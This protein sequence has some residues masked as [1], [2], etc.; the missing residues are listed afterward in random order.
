MA[1]SN[2]LIAQLVKV[3]KPTEKGA[4]EASVYGTAVVQNETQYVRI[5]GSDTLTPV[6]ST[7]GMKTNDRVIVRIKD[8]TA[9]VTGNLTSRSASSDDLGAVSDQITDVE[10]LI[11]DRVDSA[12]G[13][14]DTLVSDNVVIKDSL[15]TAEATIA[16]LVA[17]SASIREKLTTNDAVI[18]NLEATKLSA[19][20]ADL[21][22]ASLEDLDAVEAV[23]YNFDATYATITSLDAV[24]AEIEDIEAS[25][26]TAEDA[27]ILYADIEF[28]NIGDAALENLFT[29]SGII[30]NLVVSEGHVTGRL[31]GVTIIGDI[32]EGGTVVADKLVIRGEDGL[33]YKLNTDGETTEAEQ[34]EYN[35]L[36]GRVITAK[37]VTAEKISVNDLVAFGATIGGFNIT[38]GSLFSGVK[39][40]VEN[41]TPGV[42]LG[43]DGQAAFGNAD[44]YLKFYA[45]YSYYQVAFDAVTGTYMRTDTQLSM[46]VGTIVEGALTEDGHRVYLTSINDVE[47]YFCRVATDYKLYISADSILFGT[48]SKYSMNDV[49]QLTDHVKIGSYVDSDT[50]EQ[51]PCVELSE[52]DSD[53]KMRLTNKKASFMD[54]VND[55]TN[56]DSDGVETENLRVKHDIR[57]YDFVWRR[58]ANGN[59]G[60]MW[61]EVTD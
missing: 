24:S 31:T 39:E 53:F 26:L 44:N 51:L 35:S 57:H 20:V 13:R 2:D 47:T 42:F 27:K 37:S 45:V 1:L 50:G 59:L 49:K 34:T 38:D 41:S 48:D 28:A 7:V 29:K 16:V 30:D 12:H 61:M 55:S 19:D 4:T 40:S 11:A 52:S 60:L 56:I 9:T 54:G 43:S 6:E 33:Y 17:D 46:P 8:H 22:Y 10:I 15:N 23:V 5:D 14:I 32:I 25:M 21:R 58:R 18:Q 3:T 36:N